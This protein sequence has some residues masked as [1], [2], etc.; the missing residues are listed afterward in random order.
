MA[1]QQ[2]QQRLH[3]KLF[4][5]NDYYDMVTQRSTPWLWTRESES[6][7]LVMA[8]P[9]LHAL[10]GVGRN[11]SGF[12][13]CAG[14]AAVPD[15]YFSPI[16]DATRDAQSG[17]DAITS[18]PEYINGGLHTLCRRQY[19]TPEDILLAVMQS[20]S[21]SMAVRAIHSGS[22]DTRS[23]SSGGS[24]GSPQHARTISLLF[25]RVRIKSRSGS[26]KKSRRKALLYIQYPRRRDQSAELGNRRKASSA[27]K[28][29]GKFGFASNH[30][31]DA[32]HG[33]HPLSGD[34]AILPFGQLLHSRG[35]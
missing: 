31:S 25:Q 10:L 18:D 22:A 30:V 27:G 11:V 4:L 33:T 15:L 2:A 13:G 1:A 29:H 16:A 8:R 32:R 34:L 23:W 20:R 28:K 21:A 17:M 14:A 19:L 24:Q 9:W 26:G 3:A 35:R 12:Y 7:L 6:L 5:I